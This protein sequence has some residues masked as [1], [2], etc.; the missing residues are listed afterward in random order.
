M[1]FPHFGCRTNRFE[2]FLRRQGMIGQADGDIGNETDSPP[3]VVEHC[4]VTAGHAGVFQLLH[5]PQADRRRQAD[6]LGEL[7]VTDP[8]IALQ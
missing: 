4:A 1:T 6:A 7:D 8:A 3:D 2:G 5:A